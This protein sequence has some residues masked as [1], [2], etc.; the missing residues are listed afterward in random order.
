MKKVLFTSVLVVFALAGFAQG[1]GQI[2]GRIMEEES[3]LPAIGASVY[4]KLG[5]RI[6]GTA[7]GVD[8]NFKIKP[9]PAGT[10]NLTVSSVGMDTVKLEGIT[11]NSNEVRPLGD[12]Y[13][14]SGSV[15]LGDG[16]TVIAYKDPLIRPDLPS[17]EALGTE[18]IQKS[19]NQRDAVGLATTVPGVQ[20]GDNGQV[21]IRGARE[22]ASTYYV[23]GMRV[24]SLDGVV[25]GQS[26]RSMNVYTGG[27]PAA[28]GDV[29]GG[30]V[31]IET[32]SY[33]DLYNQW[34]ARQ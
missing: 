4:V 8:G 7:T 10:Y 12:I 9:L 33:F 16:I 34:N 2:N 27:I 6:I 28:Y 3:G 29:T 30:V 32:K 18:M 1:N 5:D 25:P 15:L 20:A 31:V 21:I 26:I 13:L 14:K 11:L 23:D 19:P 17:M 24:K 22:G